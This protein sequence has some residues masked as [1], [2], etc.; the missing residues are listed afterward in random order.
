MY[1]WRCSSWKMTFMPMS[2]CAK[3]YIEPCAQ[4]E[5]IVGIGTD[6]HMAPE[7][8][9]RIASCFPDCVR[10][11]TPSPEACQNGRDLRW[12]LSF[13]KSQGTC[14]TLEVYVCVHTCVY[15]RVHSKGR[16][17]FSSIFSRTWRR[18]F[19]P[20]YPMSFT[21]GRSLSSRESSNM[22]CCSVQ[23]S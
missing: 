8:V 6:A 12:S 9:L 11:M 1:V 7:A 2:A 5:I 3:A 18:P 4:E 22:F 13:L 20:C 15:S 21:F 10:V 23:N 14:A 17:C 16:A 19:T